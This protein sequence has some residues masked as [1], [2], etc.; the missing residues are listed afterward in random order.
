MDLI[1]AASERDQL[2]AEFPYWG[3]FHDPYAE[4]WYAVH[5][6]SHQVVARTPQ[7]LRQQII[8][9]VNHSGPLPAVDSQPS[10]P[11]RANPLSA[12]DMSWLRDPYRY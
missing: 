4:R 9:G 8:Q 1:N 12:Q 2:R 6:S 5:G 10:Q 3:I 7:E 11:S